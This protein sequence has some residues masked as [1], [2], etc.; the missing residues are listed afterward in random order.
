MSDEFDTSFYEFRTESI[1]GSDYWKRSE[2]TEQ[3]IVEKHEQQI[4]CPASFKS[5]YGYFQSSSSLSIPQGS[6]FEGS[7]VWSFPYCRAPKAPKVDILKIN[8]LNWGSITE[9][10]INNFRKASQITSAAEKSRNIVLMSFPVIS[11]VGAEKFQEELETLEYPEH[12]KSFYKDSKELVKK[13]GLF[14]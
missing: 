7:S 8:H 4:G 5:F 12:I 1:L 6:L 9:N 11:G 14:P 13:L 10:E 3:P 2:T